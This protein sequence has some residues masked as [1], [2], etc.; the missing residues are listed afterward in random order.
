MTLEDEIRAAGAVADEALLTNDA[1]L[2]STFFTDGWVFVSPSGIT[3]KSELIGWIASGRLAHHTM[4]TVGPERIAQVGDTVV[5]TARRASS[6]TWEGTPYATEE[7]IT[8][9]LVR[10]MD[11][12]WRAAF[13]HKC[14]V[15]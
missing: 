4:A 7:W 6:G 9:I 3:T 8:E 15:S 12:R 1:E 2:I 11:D 10:G 13:A 5:V 14:A